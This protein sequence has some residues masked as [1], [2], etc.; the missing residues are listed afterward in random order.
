MLVL[1]HTNAAGRFAR[2]VNDKTLSLICFISDFRIC[3][4]KVKIQ[5]GKE[6][7]GECCFAN[8]TQLKFIEPQLYDH[9]LSSW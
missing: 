5:R 4:E 9:D 3:K 8:V 7:F 1:N 6:L 2:K